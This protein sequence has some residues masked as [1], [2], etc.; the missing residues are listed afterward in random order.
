MT[1]IHR[2]GKATQ[3][4]NPALYRY[5]LSHQAPEHD[6]LSRLRAVTSALPNHFMQITPEQGHF[7]A[8]L[9][10][11]AGS[12]YVLELGTFTG[13]SALA[14]A[15]AIPDDGRI[16]TCD[17][18]DEYVQV[19]RRYWT[20]AGV[21]RKIEVRLGR[22][23]DTLDALERDELS[24]DAVF[25]DADKDNYEA[26]YEAALRLV[27]TGGLVMLD[28]MLRLGRVIDPEDREAGTMVIRKLNDRIAAD[29]RVDRVLLPIGDGV[30]LVR[31]H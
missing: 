10:R 28:N 16:V 11:L 8:F 19:A 21:A 22:A 6:V 20:E 18:S 31:R 27:R 30:T 2:E 25:I 24:F 9:L 13:Y 29:T 15:L 1:A 5:V 14:M 7:M 3:A 4:P 12:R 23:L 17:V 26:Y